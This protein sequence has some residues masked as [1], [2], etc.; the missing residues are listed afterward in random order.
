MQ[1]AAGIE[2]SAFRVVQEGLTN[3]LKHAGATSVA[4][5]IRYTADGVEIDVVDDGP[6]TRTR[7]ETGYGLLGIRERVE[8]YGG[9]VESGRRSEGG[10]RLRARLPA[11]A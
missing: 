11:Q 10:W 5:L 2:L 1:L 7:G 3:A 8:L 4:V 9:A 6:G